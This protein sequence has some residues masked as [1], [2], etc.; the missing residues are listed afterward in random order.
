[1]MMTIVD[2]HGLPLTYVVLR[3]GGRPCELT[4]TSAARPA[5]LFA[6]F[7]CRGGRVITLRAAETQLSGRLETRWAGCRRVWYLLTAAEIDA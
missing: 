4:I 6:Y 5:A 7:F 1:M 3:R 2:E